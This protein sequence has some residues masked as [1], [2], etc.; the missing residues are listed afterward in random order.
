[1][2]PAT[3]KRLTAWRKLVSQPLSSAAL[4]GIELLKAADD[5]ELWAIV[6]KWLSV[7]DKGRVVIPTGCELRT[8]VRKEFRGEVA[9]WALRKTGR[10]DDVTRLFVRDES[11]NNLD[12]LQGLSSLTHLSLSSARNLTELQ[13]LSQLASLDALRLPWCRDLTSLHGMREL[14]VLRTVELYRC[15]ALSGFTPLLELPMLELVDLR[16]CPHVPTAQRTELTGTA[17][18]AFL[19]EL[20]TA[21]H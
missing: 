18:D 19:G 8:R 21:G 3:A 1:V 15:P 10:L 14:P 6:A 20:R 4:E 7:D 13:G 2:S 17:L 5:P 11:F 16:H 12:M 9:L